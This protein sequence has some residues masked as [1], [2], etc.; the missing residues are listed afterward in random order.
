MTTRR[1]RLPL[2]PMARNAALEAAKQCRAA[3]VQ[4]HPEAPIGGAEYTA[5]GALMEALDGFA[6]TLTGQRRLWHSDWPPG[7]HPPG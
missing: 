2:S 7:D 5:A 1:K 6:E 3:M 4:V